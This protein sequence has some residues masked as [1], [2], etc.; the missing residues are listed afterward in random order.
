MRWVPESPEVAEVAPPDVAG[1]SIEPLVRAAEAGTPPSTD[2]VDGFLHG[3]AV[4]VV[5]GSQVT[6]VFRGEADDVRLRHWVYGLQTATS[7]HR[8]AG[9]DLWYDVLELPEGSRVEYKFEVVRGGDVQ[10]VNDPLNPHRARD[11]FGANSVCHGAGYA[12]PEWTRPD[13]ESPSGSLEDR[14]FRSR[15]LGGSRRVTIYRPARFR[16]TRRYP[17]LLVHDGGDYLAYAGLQ[18]VLDNL[19]HRLEIPGVI[20]ALMHPPDRMEQYR[21]SEAHSRYLVEELLPDLEAALPVQGTRAGRC[22]MGASLGA[23]ASLSTAVRYPDV[24]GSLLLQSG[25]FAF[26]DI[27][28]HGRGPVFDPIADFVNA[29]RRAP[30]R[31]ADKVFVSCGMYES[32]IYENRSLVPVLERTGMEVRFEEAR[33]GHNWENWRDRL[34]LGLSW[35]MPGPLW[36]VYD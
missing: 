28:G 30:K 9:T 25:S 1:L 8:L 23:V 36:L 18:T 5:D 10:W 26:S 34:R 7:L 20:A 13:P 27:G 19:I 31:V 22:L 3:R 16:E 17:L 2:A 11:P 6:F 24:F 35:L 32:L 4:P 33:D 21:G 29:Y 12:V 15:A 14:L